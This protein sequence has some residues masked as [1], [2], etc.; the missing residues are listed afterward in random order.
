MLKK[1]LAFFIPDKN[2]QLNVLKKQSD[3]WEEDYLVKKIQCKY[4]DIPENAIRE[5]VK[6]CYIEFRSPEPGEKLV[7]CVMSRLNLNGDNDFIGL[8]K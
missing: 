8:N 1:W 7:K 4:G 5:A 6:S 2:G 3:S